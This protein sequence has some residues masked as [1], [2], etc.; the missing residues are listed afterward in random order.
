MALV[1]IVIHKP[2]AAVE[3][4]G[5]VDEVQVARPGGELE[6]GGAR[7]GLNGIESLPLLAVEDG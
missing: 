1:G 3:N 4:G 6:L 2:I 5:V 7:D